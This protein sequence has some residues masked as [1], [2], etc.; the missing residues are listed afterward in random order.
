MFP[1]QRDKMSLEEVDRKLGPII[2]MSFL[3]PFNGEEAT[4][5]GR[6]VFVSYFEYLAA[7]DNPLAR[8]EAMKEVLVGSLHD[9]YR[10]DLEDSFQLVVGQ[11]GK[12]GAVAMEAPTSSTSHSPG[13]W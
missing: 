13:A 4:E 6:D 10:R 1:V 11:L 8:M 7:Q 9:V 3:E 2:F 5:Q 12:G